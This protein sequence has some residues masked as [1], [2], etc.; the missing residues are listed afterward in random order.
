LAQYV[1]ENPQQ[2]RPERLRSNVAAK[3]TASRHLAQDSVEHLRKFTSTAIQNVSAISLQKKKGAKIS[4]FFEV[5]Q[6]HID[7]QFQLIAEG[8]HARDCKPNRFVQLAPPLF[9]DGGEQAW[10]VFEMIQ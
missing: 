6:K 2:R 5:A 7:T 9:Q 4:V 8:S 1:L 3:L 10:L